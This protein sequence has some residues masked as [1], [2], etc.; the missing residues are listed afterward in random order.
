MDAVDYRDDL[1][2]SAGRMKWWREEDMWRGAQRHR[3]E[4]HELV[5]LL[6][7]GKAPWGFTLR[8]GTEH[9]EPLLITK[10]EEGSVA[11]AVSL[12]AGDEMMSVNAVPLSGSRQEAI[13]LVKSS[14]KTLSLVVRSWYDT[15]PTK[16]HQLQTSTHSLCLWYWE[17]G[18]VAL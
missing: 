2:L 5:E 4:D 3:E 6:L 14:H 16:P 8:G 12:Q 17:T 11:A 13:C 7:R 1:R 10:V 9:R 15:D 18:R